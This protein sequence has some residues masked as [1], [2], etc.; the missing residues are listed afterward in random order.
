MTIPVRLALLASAFL[1]G[2]CAETGQ[3]TDRTAVPTPSEAAAAT[4][5][6]SLNPAAITYTCGGHPFA[7]DVFDEPEIDLRATAAGIALAEFIEKGEYADLVPATGWRLAGSDSASTSFVAAVPG[8]PPFAEAEAALEDGVWRIVGWGQCRPIVALDGLRGGDWVLAQGQ[9]VDEATTS[10]FVDVTEIECA[11][12][13]EAGD[14]LRPPMIAYDPYRVVILFTLLPPPGQV[15]ECP[16]NPSTRV[17]VELREPLGNRELI[18]G[19]RAPWQ[20]QR[21]PPGG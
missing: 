4:P 13:Q 17:E 8:D 2:A 20:D 21:R 1:L 6:E 10:F 18:D 11:S 19:S 14:R 5:I 7:L 16:G 9:R 15:F 12:G 3:G